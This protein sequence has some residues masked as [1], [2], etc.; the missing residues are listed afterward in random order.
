[1]NTTSLQVLERSGSSNQFVTYDQKMLALQQEQ[2]ISSLWGALPQLTT[3]DPIHSEPQNSQMYQGE[4]TAILI[5]ITISFVVKNGSVSF[6]LM[7]DE[8]SGGS[9]LFVMRAFCECGVSRPKLM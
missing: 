6:A 7:Q 2:L 9:P 1:M 4:S 5:T 3:N 8:K